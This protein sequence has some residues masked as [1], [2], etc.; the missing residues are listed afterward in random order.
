MLYLACF[1]TVFLFSGP[2][3]FGCLGR[4]PG[5][6]RFCKGQHAPYSTVA[7]GLTRVAPRPIHDILSR[8]CFCARI[9]H[10]FIAPPTCIA[11]TVA[12]LLQYYC[13]IFDPLPTPCFHVIH[14]TI[15]LIT[16]SC[17]GQHAPYSTVAESVASREEMDPASLA[18]SVAILFHDYWA[19]YTPLSNPPFSRHTPCDIINNNVV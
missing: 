15:L 6:R 7:E 16:I 13:A 11:H 1:V 3:V 14:P 8:V 19:V 4:S 18:H 2:S 17:K 10:P 5:E 12:I 9:N